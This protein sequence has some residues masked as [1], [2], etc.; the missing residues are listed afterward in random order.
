MAR[1]SSV[2]GR[3][4]ERERHVDHRLEIGDGDVLVGVWMSIIPFA[5]FT[6][7]ETALVE[8]VR[9]GGTAG[10]LVRDLVPA[11]LRAPRQRARP[12]RSLFAKR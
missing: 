1:G 7:C 10:E 8:D 9:V 11:A 12:P 4:D 6:H 3:L 5:R 2:T